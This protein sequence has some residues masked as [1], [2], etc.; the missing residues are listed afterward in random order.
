MLSLIKNNKRISKLCYKLSYDI[1]NINYPF[2]N[3]YSDI[4]LQNLRKEKNNTDED[5]DGWII[6]NTIND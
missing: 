5:E 4:E 2:Y 1:M 6:I 3:L